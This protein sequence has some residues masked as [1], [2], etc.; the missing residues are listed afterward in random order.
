MKV[1]V[2][3]ATGF[4]GRFVA[5]ELLARGV[6]VRALT[7]G[8]PTVPLPREVELATGDVLS[9]A[10]LAP[11][12]DGVDAVVHLAGRVERGAARDAL[13]ALHVDG[14]A[15]LLRAMHAV[16]CKN[17]VYASTSGVVAVGPDPV[18]FGDEAPYADAVVERWPYYASKIAAEKLVHGMASRLG[19]G[20]VT[21]R[22]SLL[23]GP[24]D[25][26]QS[27]TG[28][29]RK[30][31]DRQ[32]PV[33]P[34]GGLSFVDVRDAAAT[35]ANAVERFPAGERYLLGGANMTMRDFFVLAANLADVPP[36]VGV[37]PR[38]LWGLGARALRRVSEWT[39][40]SDWLGDAIPDAVS[41]E[42]GDHF[43]YC[44]WT[45]A[46]AELGH[47]PRSPSETLDDTITWLRRFGQP[48]LLTA[49][50]PRRIEGR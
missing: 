17:L 46:V 42:M 27:S 4:L 1:L 18:V 5:R 22:P 37:V 9:E 16:G 15:N 25:W 35:F 49:D 41:M 31:L 11:A 34:R 50:D 21:L 30:V 19:V 39:D 45:R 36:P 23:L 40:R 3:G 29:V 6:G 48:E 38:R 2:T 26:G 13:Y 33:S 12:V 7:R 32:V 20:V 44:D 28:E 43:W 10:T 47:A 24:E 8:V 14:S